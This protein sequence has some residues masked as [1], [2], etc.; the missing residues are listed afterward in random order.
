MLNLNTLPT[1]NVQSDTHFKALLLSDCNY[2]YQKPAESHQ[3]G[4]IKML[5]VFCQ[6]N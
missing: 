5:S 3:Y 1:D 4:F 6:M 2:V